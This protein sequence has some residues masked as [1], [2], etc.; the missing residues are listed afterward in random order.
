MI[1]N[2]EELIRRCEKN[3]RHAQEFLF[4]QFYKNIYAIAMRYLSD[5]HDAE[6][7][8]I[9]SFTRVFKKFKELYLQ[10]SGKPG[11]MDTYDINQ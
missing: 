7:A 2:E 11:K 1:L 6:D 3:D 4:N 8:I 5:H 10:W 9:Q